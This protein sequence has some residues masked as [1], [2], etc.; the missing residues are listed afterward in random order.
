MNP[1][2]N[3]LLVELCT[4][5]LDAYEGMS[6]IR[7]RKDRIR[8]AVKQASDPSATPDIR[9]IAPDLAPA[10]SILLMFIHHSHGKVRLN[11]VVQHFSLNRQAA[12]SRM[13][14]L[15]KAGYLEQKDTA[16]GL[17][18]ITRKGHDVASLLEKAQNTSDNPDLTAA[19]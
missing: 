13:Q 19:T 2:V 15:L 1:I 16:Y 9:K 7:D 5:F 3:E 8:A 11:E 6:E 18:F 12:Y 17:Y 14:R 10:T 4:Q